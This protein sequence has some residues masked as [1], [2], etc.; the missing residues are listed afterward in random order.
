MNEVTIHDALRYG[1]QQLSASPSPGL[2]ARLLLQ[3][4]TGLT[5]GALVA[6]DEEILSNAHRHRYE[7]LLS[8]A[9]AGE[10]IP[11]LTGTAP[12]YDGDFLVSPAVLIPRP[13][14]EELVTH[15]LR[16]ARERRAVLAVDVGT[17]SGC[18]PVTLARHLPHATVVALD[19][20]ASA[21]NVA[22]RNVQRH[23]LSRRV[24]LVQANLWT[25]FGRVG[26]RPLLITANLPYVADPE[27][28]ELSDGVKSYEPSLALRGGPDGLDLIRRLLTQLAASEAF[29]PG[30][31]DRAVFL[32]IGWRQGPAVR[33]LARRIMPHLR[34]T[35]VHDY[36]GHDRIVALTS[37][38]LIQL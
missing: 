28:T 12:F 8:R 14:T 9:A 25:S 26:T 23:H 20:S 31:R 2:D 27:W 30:A 13:E 34:V 37:E 5:Y 24:H 16:W 21:L 33:A 4:V 10:P 3:H 18:I 7:A 6:R 32:E 1:T 22:A 29:S 11:Y 19:L 38:E 35:V 36:A 17:G 15:A